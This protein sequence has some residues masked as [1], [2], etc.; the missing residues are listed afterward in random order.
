MLDELSVFSM[1]ETK[2]DGIHSRDITIEAHRSLTVA[3]VL[4]ILAD[5]P[6]NEVVACIQFA[7]V[8]VPDSYTFSPWPRP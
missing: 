4:A 5:R 1:S 6:R 3:Q 2:D 7:G 8:T